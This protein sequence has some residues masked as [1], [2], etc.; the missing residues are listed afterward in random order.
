MEAGNGRLFLDT[1]TMAERIGVKTSWLYR[2]CMR[3][4]PGSIPRV[5]V[6]KYN[7]WVEADVLAWLKKQSEAALQ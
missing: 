6:G 5:K 1:P 2:A 4:G 7:K 3:K